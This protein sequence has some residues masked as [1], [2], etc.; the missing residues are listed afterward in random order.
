MKPI[1][2]YLRFIYEVTRNELLAVLAMTL[3]LDVVMLVLFSFNPRNVEGVIIGNMSTNFSIYVIY[4]A[5]W[6]FVLSFKDFSG[7]ISLRANRLCFLMSS[8]IAIVLTGFISVVALIVNTTVMK[9]IGRLLWGQSTIGVL[10]MLH[11]NL[12]RNVI[13]IFGTY[14]FMA[15]IGFLV[16]AVLYRIRI[17]TAIILGVMPIATLFTMIQIDPSLLQTVLNNSLA[18]FQHYMVNGLYSF[19]WAVLFFILSI[20]L[21]KRAPIRPY[22]HDLI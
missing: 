9:I 21:L 2:G 14:L 11:T 19:L 10:E 18:F 20:F 6:A 17:I 22:A 15:G 1:K 16:G 7:A 3:A 12:N 4:I 13:E 5:T 8:A